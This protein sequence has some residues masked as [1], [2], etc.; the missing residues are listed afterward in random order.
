MSEKVNLLI[1]AGNTCIKLITYTQG[2][3]YT[4]ST[5]R[6][7]SAD[8]MRASIQTA[9]HVYLSN[10]GANHIR[11]QIESICTENKA[12]LFVAE[13]QSK[14]FGLR[15]A[16][17]TPSNMGVDRWLAMLACMQKSQMQT[18]LT[19]D[20]GTAMTIDAV[21]KGQHIG[22]WIVP[23]ITLLRQSLFKNTQGVF[24]NDEKVFSTAFGQDTPECVNNGCSAQILGALL[25]AEK[26]MQKKSKKFEIFVTGGDKS[27]F[28]NTGFE[29]II[30][31]ENLVFDGLTLFVD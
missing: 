10:V 23:G 29:N 30:E 27:I 16:Y 3:G 19:V 18:F 2:L 20:I 14:A 6:Y 11:Q 17:Q 25:L 9:T 26:E 31:C 24:G 28:K 1:D 12:Q 21:H 13:T 22:G 4:K 5:Q 15:N 7:Q 8:E